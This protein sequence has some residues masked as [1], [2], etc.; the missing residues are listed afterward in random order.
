LAKVTDSEY[1]SAFG[2]HA[3][4]TN[5]NNAVALG[6]SSKVEGVDSGV[7]LGAFSVADKNARIFGYDRR[8]A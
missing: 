7:A 6:V 5:A 1:G 2:S 3:T 4:V 8:R